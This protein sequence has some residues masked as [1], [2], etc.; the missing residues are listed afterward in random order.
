MTGDPA[1]WSE[2]SALIRKHGKGALVQA[3]AKV[4]QSMNAG[5]DVETLRWFEIHECVE[6]MLAETSGWP[7][8]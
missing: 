1:C 7:V 3:S 5:N 2:A 4:S 6:E 8:D